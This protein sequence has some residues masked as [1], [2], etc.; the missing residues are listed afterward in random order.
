MIVDLRHSFEP[1]QD[2]VALSRA[3]TL[4]GLTVEGLPNKEMAPDEQVIEFLEEND[5]MPAIDCDG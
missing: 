5:L 3:K 4:E 1:G 2:Y